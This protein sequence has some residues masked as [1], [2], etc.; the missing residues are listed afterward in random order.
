MSKRYCCSLK[1]WKVV[2]GARSDLSVIKSDLQS[3]QILSSSLNLITGMLHHESAHIT[4]GG[5]LPGP[6]LLG[7]YG[8]V[9]KR[10][11]WMPRQ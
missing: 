1:I 2:K 11:R 7:L 6:D 4:T 9:N 5:I 3:G 8:Q 10:I